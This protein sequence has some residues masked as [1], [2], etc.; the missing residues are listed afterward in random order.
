MKT[1]PYSV[2]VI[3]HNHRTSMLIAGENKKEVILKAKD[4]LKEELF[5]SFGFFAQI[6]E[7][8]KYEVCEI[9]SIS[10]SPETFEAFKS[11]P[12]VKEYLK[13]V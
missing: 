2:H 10:M 3:C 8:F 9:T 5:T 6:M 13:T 11:N 12:N 1:K 4:R 7:S